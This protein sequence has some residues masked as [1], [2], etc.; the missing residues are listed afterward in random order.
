MGFSFT[1]MA[2]AVAMTTWSAIAVASAP[3]LPVPDGVYGVGVAKFELVDTSR[4][5]AAGD[6]ASGPRQLPVIAWY[7]AKRP[8]TRVK[9]AA[10]MGH[11]AT[12]V[13]LPA[14]ARNLGY[15]PKDLQPLAVLRTYARP[16]APP[17]QHPGGFP[18]VIFSHGFFLYPEQDTALA[19]R[20]ASH[21]YI[22]LSVAHPGD[23]ADVRLENGRIVATMTASE[24]DDPGFAKAFDAL[25]RGKDLATCRQA[26]ADY[27]KAFHA[28]RMG[29]SS[30]QWRDD[31]L[32]VARTIVG[33]SG[34]KALRDVLVGAD[35]NRL[36]FAGMSFGGATAAAS[37]RRVAACRAAVNLDGQNF[38]PDLFDR[39]VDRPLLLMLSDWTRYG[40]FKGQSRDADFSP[41]DL[42]YEPWSEA[43]EDPDVIRVRL[44]GARHLGFT[45]LVALLDG[46]KRDSRVGEI[47]SGEAM[48]AI[49][50]LVLAFLDAY[51][52]DG[53]PAGI[54]R[55]IER[56]P[57]LTRHVPKR[58]REWTNKSGPGAGAQTRHNAAAT[59]ESSGRQVDMAKPSGR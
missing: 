27:A 29:R 4:P 58:V 35:R 37:C 51:V 57:V 36:V 30:V 23:A 43:G 53:N 26:L 5:L 6:P 2:T 45:D 54:D 31:T 34:P 1:A 48:P 20:L 33:K 32:F 28:T 16:G 41:N 25:V 7:P 46:P 56:H 13:T 22:V 40:L 9:D 47:G 50:D 59:R 17:V 24:G 3:A 49:G 12:T 14:V 11:D 8:S 18:V 42:A 38:D 19:T 39:S 44:K 52:R 10:Y 55:A 15:A 21:G